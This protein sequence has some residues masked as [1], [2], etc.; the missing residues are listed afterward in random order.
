MSQITTTFPSYLDTE[1]HVEQSVD[2]SDVTTE[3]KQ[4]IP[5]IIPY[6]TCV[7]ANGDIF[8]LSRRPQYDLPGLELWAL[9]G[10]QKVSLLHRRG[11]RYEVAG[12]AFNPD[13]AHKNSLTEAFSRIARSRLS[14]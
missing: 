8:Q 7:L 9:K 3:F 5:F 12:L 4:T 13:P 1:K 10:G 6:E 14:P 11:G 2:E